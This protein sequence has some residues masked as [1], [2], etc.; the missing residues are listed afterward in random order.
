MGGRGAPVSQRLAALWAVTSEAPP[1]AIDYA[2]MLLVGFTL[3]TTT[4][5]ATS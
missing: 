2:A 1:G 4:R 3:M 5:A